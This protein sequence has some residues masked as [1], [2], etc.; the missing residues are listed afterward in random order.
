MSAQLNDGEDDQQ[1]TLQMI[2]MLNQPLTTV[3]VWLQRIA[4][5]PASSA[6]KQEMIVATRIERKWQAVLDI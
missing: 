5:F 3:E 4:A 2:R 6:E 1:V